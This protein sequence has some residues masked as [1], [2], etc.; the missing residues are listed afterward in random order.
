MAATIDAKVWKHYIINGCNLQNNHYD[1][2]LFFISVR[3][4]TGYCVVA[5]FIVQSESAKCIKEAIAVLQG[6]NPECD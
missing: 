3:T 5:E 2:P 4:N 1:L 6:W